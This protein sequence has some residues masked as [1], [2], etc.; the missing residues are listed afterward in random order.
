MQMR[1]RE[2]V[3]F[4]LGLVWAQG[5]FGVGTTTPT[6]RLDVEGGRLRVRA[7]SGTGTRLATVD[8]TGVFGTLAGT[9]PGDVLQW[10]GTAW[11]PTALSAGGDN[12]GTQVAATSG[13]IVGNGT[14]G[15]P[16]TFAPG[17]AAGQVWQW[18]GTSWVLTTVAAAGDNWGTQVAATSSPIVGNG[19]AGSP[20]GLQ[21]GTAAGQ[22]LVWNGTTWTIGTA[23]GDNWGSQVAATSGPIV[24]NGTA[25]S[26]IT[27][28]PGTAAGQVWQWN[29]TSWVLTTVAAAGD[30]WGTQVAVTSSPIVGNGT[31]GSPIGLQPGTSPG[32][33]L[34]WTGAA[35]SVATP[36]VRN[37]LTFATTPTPAIELG[38]PL[39]KNTDIGLAG[40]VF[41][42]SG[43]GRVGIGLAAPSAS[44]KVHIRNTDIT[45]GPGVLI[46]QQAAGGTHGLSVFT[47]SGT[48]NTAA[49]RGEHLNTT[50][51]V[52]GVAGTV[53]S[54][55]SASAGVFGQSTGA[56]VG[57]YGINTS[58]GHGVYGIANHTTA[59]SGVGVVATHAHNLGAGLIAIGGAITTPTA[60]LS[61]GTTGEAID[62][63]GRWIGTW[64]DASAAM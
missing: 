24:G 7:Y 54:S 49:I 12:W 42:L 5:N 25:G 44:S 45:G 19:T 33:I 9:A 63:V 10:N 41:T 31:A 11:V 3:A 17:T 30:N 57:V 21:P 34:I 15:S 39:I 35:W 55:S 37:G 60:I 61:P 20:I 18:N 22:T 1:M 27:F 23:P 2:A 51:G 29:G 59:S 36:A 50:A 43:N 32:Q 48:A 16:I 52:Y 4:F 14:A 26:P 28:A 40:F 47:S 58:T 56:G 53:S 8:P 46:E 13:P 62:A 38:G 6:E 64:S